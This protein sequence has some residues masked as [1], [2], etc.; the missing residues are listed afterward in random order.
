MA[1]G[2]EVRPDRL[3]GGLT[4]RSRTR[5]SSAAAGVSEVLAERQK[6][7]PAVNSSHLYLIIP[8]ALFMKL[9]ASSPVALTDVSQPAVPRHDQQEDPCGSRL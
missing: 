6:C 7:G 4:T 8:I 9:M 1:D 5:R 3:F 2:G